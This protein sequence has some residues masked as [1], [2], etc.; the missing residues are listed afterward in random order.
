MPEQANCAPFVPV[1]PDHGLRE[2]FPELFDGNATPLRRVHARHSRIDEF[3]ARGNQPPIIVKTITVSSSPEH[4]ARV[5]GEE[6]A[7]LRWLHA[8][9]DATLR[10][11]I[12]EPLAWIPG[13]PAVAMRKLDGV[14][15][16]RLLRCHAVR[17]AVWGGAPLARIGAQVG[18]WLRA[19]HD[20][21]RTEDAAVNADRVL[22]DIDLSLE[23]ASAHGLSADAVA[24]VRAQARQAIARLGFTPVPHAARQG[25]FTVSNILIDGPQVRIVEFDGRR[26]KRVLVKVIG[27]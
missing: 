12:P 17:G 8:R 14:T 19:M 13:S 9:M 6:F 26:A 18:R 21:T 5:A 7:A 2:R 1:Q 23:E 27:D 20:A 24:Q 4:A 11:T 15:V 10:E 25:D 22:A 3:R 16:A